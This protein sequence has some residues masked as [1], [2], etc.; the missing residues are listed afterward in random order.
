MHQPAQAKAG[1]R[2]LRVFEGEVGEEG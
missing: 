2:E 1:R